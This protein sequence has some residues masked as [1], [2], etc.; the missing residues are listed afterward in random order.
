LVYRQGR[1]IRGRLLSARV[2][3]TG[4]RETR[5][6]FAVGKSIGKAVVRNR[7]KRQLRG[8]AA[9]LLP[10]EGWDVVIGASAAVKDVSFED[11]AKEVRGLMRKADVTR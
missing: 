7:I 11:L 3:A 5:F 1:L 2:L 8:A 4:R 10:N 6:G 9:D